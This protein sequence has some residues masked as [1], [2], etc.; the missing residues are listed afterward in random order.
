MGKSTENCRFLMGKSTENCLFFM[1]KSTE[2]CH[3]KSTT[4]FTPEISEFH[5]LELLGPLS[6]N[7]NNLVDVSDTFCFSARWRARGSP[8]RK[9]GGVW[10]FLEIPR[11]GGGGSSRRGGGEG[12]GKVSAGNWGGGGFNIFFGAEMPAKKKNTNNNNNA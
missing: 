8:G 6:C 11:G 10:F 2:N 9:R 3:Q 1:G 4:C 7:R 5:H 12:A